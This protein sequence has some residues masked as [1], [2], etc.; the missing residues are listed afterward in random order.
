MICFETCTHWKA[1]RKVFL[2]V[3]LRKV[4]LHFPIKSWRNLHYSSNITIP[5]FQ[6]HKILSLRGMGSFVPLLITVVTA[7]VCFWNDILSNWRISNKAPG[8]DAEQYWAKLLTVRLDASWHHLYL[9]G[10]NYPRESVSCHV[11][12]GLLRRKY[13]AQYCA[14]ANLRILFGDGPFLTFKTMIGVLCRSL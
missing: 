12:A 10:W 2:Y 1:D 7:L 13:I 6:M 11:F 4:R 5:F 8:V 3:L 9:F 14:F